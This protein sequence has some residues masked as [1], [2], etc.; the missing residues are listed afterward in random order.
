V[1]WPSIALVVGAA[2]TASILVTAWP[3]SR[4]AAIRPA[5]ALRIA[6]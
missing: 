6:D 4:A 2:L 3:A 1:P 5:V